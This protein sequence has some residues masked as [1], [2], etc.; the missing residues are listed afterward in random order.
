MSP[1]SL[2]ETD[3]LLL[4]GLF[5]DMLNYTLVLSVFPFRL[6]H[7]KYSN[8]SELNGWLFFIFVSGLVPVCTLV[9]SWSLI[10]YLSVRRCCTE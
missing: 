7:L 4:I 1:L 5:V 2:T 9:R 10:G 6:E 8:V 3:L